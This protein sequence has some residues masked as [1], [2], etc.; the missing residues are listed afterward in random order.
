[1]VRKKPAVTKLQKKPLIFLLIGVLVMAVLVFS[2]GSVR[3]SGDIRSHAAGTAIGTYVPGQLIIKVKKGYSPSQ[4]TIRSL[5]EYSDAT[6]KRLHKDIYLVK[7]TKLS[8]KFTSV[9]PSARSKVTATSPDTYTKKA[10]QNLENNA[11]ILIASADV[12]GMY[13]AVPN[14]EN[15]PG[16]KP[17]LDNLGIEQSWDRVTAGSEVIIGVLDSGISAPGSLSVNPD[18]ANRMWVNTSEKNGSSGVDD[19]G[20]GYI[21]DFYGYFEEGLGP[22]DNVTHGIHVAGIISAEYNNQKDIAGL[23]MH[24]R[25]M[26]LK[27]ANNIDYGTFSNV[28]GSMGYAMK[29]KNKGVNIVAINHSYGFPKESLDADSL[30]LLKQT[31]I[32]AKNAG[33]V[34]VVSAGNQHIVTSQY[35]ALFTSEDLVFTV[36]GVTRDGLL[37]GFSNYGTADTEVDFAAPGTDSGANGIISLKNT[38]GSVRLEG[39]SMATPHVTGLIGLMFSL[40]RDLKYAQI[41]TILTAT[42]DNVDAV[43]LDQYKGKLGFGRIHAERAINKL[44]ADYGITTQPTPTPVSPTTTPQAPTNTLYPSQ[45]PLPTQSATYLTMTN[46]KAG[47]SYASPLTLPVGGR[48]RTLPSYVDVHIFSYPIQ[49]TVPVASQRITSFVPQSG[50][51]YFSTWFATTITAPGEYALLVMPR[52]SSGET[53]GTDVEI[54][55]FVQNIPT[56]TPTP[57]PRSGLTIVPT[58]FFQ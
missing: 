44:I 36:V 29:Q 15:Y 41:K 55:F 24:C 26:S 6:V 19:D 5:T 56:K 31:F 33:I 42:T 14:D 48:I 11:N 57:K 35:P 18:L 1:M 28:I 37:A 30:Q 25:I 34:S 46:P 8:R 47:N 16:Q 20:N 32:D 51:Y 2:S 53:V 54:R 9:K 49:S 13:D 7:S 23:C 40:K 4:K 38:T 12:I 21:D 3:T 27:S 17:Y 50:E 43:Q 22:S 45:K 10:I 58:G 52:G 39:T